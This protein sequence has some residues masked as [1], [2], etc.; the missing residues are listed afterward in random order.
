MEQRSTRWGTISVEAIAD[1][2]QQSLRQE[3]YVWTPSAEISEAVYGGF[4]IE[5]QSSAGPDGVRRFAPADSG[6]L[7]IDAA[8]GGLAILTLLKDLSPEHV[9]SYRAM[10]LL[11]RR[12]PGLQENLGRTLRRQ[13]DLYLTRP[14]RVRPDI[15]DVLPDEIGTRAGG[16]RWSVTELMRQGRAAAEAL[17]NPAPDEAECIRYGLLEAARRDPVDVASLSREEV[18]RYLRLGL[19]DLGPGK[20]APDL[21]DRVEERLLTAIEKKQDATPE[22]FRRWWYIEFDNV[23]HA[24]AKAKRNGGPIERAEVRQAV[25][26]LVFRSFTYVG[27]C[28]AI[29]MRAFADALPTPL[30]AQERVLFDAVYGLQDALGGL[31]LILLHDRFP[32]LREIILEI[33]QTPENPHLWGVFLRML[34][35]HAEMVQRKRESER[36]YSPRRQAQKGNGHPAPGAATHAEPAGH[37]AADHNLFQQI[38]T[39][40]R[41]M[42]GA[43]CPCGSTRRWH[44]DYN[45][46][47]SSSE[48][49]HWVDHCPKCRQ[50]E[51]VSVP[52]GEFRQIVDLLRQ[53]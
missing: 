47:G 6:R 45:D 34:Q 37:G 17:G 15:R 31:P 13:Q 11:H 30:T 2:N 16:K 25:L 10:H 46:E 38:A 22:Q 50:E 36:V 39:E 48:S 7:I 14:E 35:F 44:A 52:L 24:I 26:E 3:R 40:H 8:H 20:I 12:A 33:W 5:L 23:V 18:M 43:S 9:K 19:F 1:D 41:E 42:R 29:Q 32:L 49:V 28:V 51:E 53:S 21:A 4:R 27:S